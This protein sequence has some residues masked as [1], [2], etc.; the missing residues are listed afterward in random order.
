MSEVKGTIKN[1]DE[2]KGFGFVTSARVGRDVF[3]H[4]TAFPKYSLDPQAGDKIL[5]TLEIDADGRPAAQSA[6]FLDPQKST[7]P[8]RKPKNRSTP[9]LLLALSTLTALLIGWAFGYVQT[10]LVVYISVIS[11]LTFLIYARDKSKAQSDGW[12]TSE[13]SLHLL[14]VFGGWPGA[15]L[16]QQ[17][18]RHKSNKVSFR[19][20]YWLTIVLNLAALVWLHSTQGYVYSAP[21]FAEIEKYAE[22]LYANLMPLLKSLWDMILQQINDVSD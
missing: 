9:S 13:R 3:V 18:L 11:F 19:R 15:A 7:R 8:N 4:K 6:K 1:W 14:G 10:V 17:W 20:V 21:Y 5:Y 2:R 16:A 12:R 22:Q